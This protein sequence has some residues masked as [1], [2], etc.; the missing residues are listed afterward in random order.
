MKDIFQSAA[1]KLT[2]WYLAIIMLL[3]IG[4]SLALY[5]V[6]A[7]DLENNANRQ[8]G[9]FEGLLGPRDLGVYSRLRNSL[10]DE[11]RGHLKANLII[12][13][14]FVLVAGGGI[15]YALARRTLRPIEDT[16]ESQKRFTGDASHEL[17]TPLA[18][19]QA[20]NEVALRN[21]NLTKGQALK[22]LQSNLE[23][24][25]KLKALSEGLLALANND[26]DTEFYQAL[27]SK[28]IIAAAI[29]RTAKA[30]KA[31]RVELDTSETP[32]LSVKGSQQNLVDVIVI[33]IDN[34]IK[35]SQPGGKVLLT[36]SERGKTARI[37]VIDSG[38]GIKAAD[39]P[40]IFERFYRAEPSRSKDNS[41]GYGLGLAIAKKIADVHGAYIDVKSAPGKG[42]TFTLVLP[43]A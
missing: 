15:S 10:L 17:R 11:D 14:L 4:T 21:P 31:R 13:N 25:A 20:E 6:S 23:E 29:A 2:G 36:T 32:D 1:L 39:L 28:E 33:L 7:S 5:H 9:Y 38:K 35:Y 24:V 8:V 3:S 37:S 42:S 12:F 30:A 19:I 22:L 26:K 34:A 41:G 27:S 43:L 16:L 18:A 40:H